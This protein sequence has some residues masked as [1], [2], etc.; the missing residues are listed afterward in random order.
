MGRLCRELLRD[1]GRLLLDAPGH[2]GELLRARAGV[3]AEQERLVAVLD[4]PERYAHRYG[5]AGKT[6]WSAMTKFS[7]R[8][9]CMLL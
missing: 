7:T 4:R 6:P 2:S 1:E 5:R 3:D 9:G 8:Y